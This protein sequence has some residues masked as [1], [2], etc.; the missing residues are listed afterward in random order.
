MKYTPILLLSIATIALSTCGE[1]LPEINR[2]V[3]SFSNA[4]FITPINNFSLEDVVEAADGGLLVVGNISSEDMGQLSP[5]I[6]KLD[7]QRAV[8]WSQILD[9]DQQNIYR[10][11]RI[12]PTLDNEYTVLTM[13]KPLGASNYNID[14]TKINTSGDIIWH[15]RIEENDKDVRPMAIVQ[16]ADEGY[17]VFSTVL[18]EEHDQLQLHRVSSQGDLI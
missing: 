9:I 7:G 6:L 4:S 10:T 14:L 1:D 13:S 16:L 18:G 5:T 17:M 11:M 2:T 12:I 8:E 3:A 15:K